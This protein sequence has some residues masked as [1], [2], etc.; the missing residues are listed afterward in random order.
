MS[1]YPSP[2]QCCLSDQAS[3]KK[4]SRTGIH[5]WSKSNKPVHVGMVRIAVK[6]QEKRR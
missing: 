3:H 2:V 4:I 5:P 1:V 6:K